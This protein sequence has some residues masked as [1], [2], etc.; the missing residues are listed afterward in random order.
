MAN[1][2]VHAF[3]GRDDVLAQML[4][5]FE[6]ASAGRTRAVLL[7]GEPGIG[8]T[9]VA[10]EF[11]SQPAVAGACALWASS[12]GDGAPPLWPWIQIVRCHLRSRGVAA[13]RDMFGA[14]VRLVDQLIPSLRTAKPSEE[15]D[16]D[17][18][19]FELFDAFATFLANTAHSEGAAVVVLDDLH[20]ADESS[21]RLAEFVLRAVRSA[22]LLVLGS[23]QDGGARRDDAMHAF[24]SSATRVPLSGLAHADLSHLL[25]ARTGTV[26]DGHVVARLHAL[27]DGNPYFTDA[28]LNTL[29]QRDGRFRL[30]DHLR[31][32]VRTRLAALS[33]G[34]QAVLGW[35]AVCGREFTVEPLPYVAHLPAGE[36]AALLAEAC[37]AGVV[38]E[39]DEAGRYRFCPALVRDIVHDDLGADQRVAMHGRVG[40]V[41]E[42]LAHGDQAERLPGLAHHY[43][44][45]APRRRTGKALHYTLEAEHSAARLLD[46]TAAAG[47][48]VRIPEQVAGP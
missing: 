44:L 22:P 45:A 21:L 42:G 38:R 19:R 2:R 7:T 41:L 39:T 35:A 18:G 4:T 27:T 5:A 14:G 8:K 3:V 43:R 30:P 17:R 11:L 26:P 40:D 24:G 46:E 47:V 13:T 34:A 9:C 25:T 48:V 29:S 33:D 15:L 6:E 23:C 32:V 31:G 1:G 37:T 36:L 12:G 10:E 16:A 28:L 20:L